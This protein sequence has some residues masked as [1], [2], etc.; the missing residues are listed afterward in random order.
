MI[1]QIRLGTDIVHIPRVKV[2]LDRFGE[3]FLH[4]VFTPTEQQDCCRADRHSPSQGDDR[5]RHISVN[6]LAGRWAA[7]EAIAKAMGTGWRGVRYTDIEIQRQPSGQPQVYLY[8]A[9]ATHTAAWGNCQWQLSLSHD[10]EYAI[11][12]AIAYCIS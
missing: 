6:Q 3:R 9:A 11:A 5:L 12:T 1:S 10:G 8:G 2:T 4:K 7:K